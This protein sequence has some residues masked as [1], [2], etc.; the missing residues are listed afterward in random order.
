VTAVATDFRPGSDTLYFLFA[1]IQGLIGMPP[2]EFCRSAGILD[3]HKVFVRDP[4]QAWY[5]RGLPD[6]GPDVDAIA[7]LLRRFVSDTGAVNVR[8]VGNSMGGYAAILFCALLGTGRAIAFAPQT[9]IGR[10]LRRE[11]QDSRWQPH[12][13][14]LHRA[15]NGGETL[16]LCACID[17]HGG[18]IDAEVHVATDDALDVVHARRLERYPSVALHWHPGGG[19]SL[20]RDLRDAGRLGAILKG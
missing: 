11:H 14:E 16:D 8:F 7:R 17:A 15:M 9:F 20:V 12:I 13:D 18:A 6:I 3:A 2:F 4:A 10:E 19:H 5:K 1:G